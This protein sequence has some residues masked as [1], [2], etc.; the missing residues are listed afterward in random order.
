MYLAAICIDSRPNRLIGGTPA[1]AC[2]LTHGQATGAH[3]PE[4]QRQ[5]GENRAACRY[6]SADRGSAQGWTDPDVNDGTCEEVPEHCPNC[7][8]GSR[9]STMPAHELGWPG[10]PT[11][12]DIAA[13][14]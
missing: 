11:G 3:A 14:G 8:S 10:P 4:E 1:P 6:P 7:G 12:R 9:G 5:R 13:A 2:C